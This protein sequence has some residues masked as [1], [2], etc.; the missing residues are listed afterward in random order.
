MIEKDNYLTKAQLWIIGAFIIFLPFNHALTFNYGF[1]IKISE[2]AI[3]LFFCSTFISRNSRKYLTIFSDT[4]FF[5][6]IVFFLIALTIST[7]VNLFWQYPY[8]LD[9]YNARFNPKAD[10]F[11]KLIY[12]F[13]AI[14]SC[15]VCIAAFKDNKPLFLNLFILGATLSSIY[16]WYLFSFSLLKIQYYTLPGSEIHPQAAL[17]KFGHFIRCGTFKEGNMMGMF[18]VTAGFIALYAKRYILAAFIFLTTITTASSMAI[19]C[20]VVFLS[21]Y[22]SWWLFMR[23]KIRILALLHISILVI[24]ISLLNFQDFKYMIS[25]IVPFNGSEYKDAVHSQSERINLA[26]VSLKIGLDNPV[27]GV[28]L[29]NFAWHYLHYNENEHFLPRKEKI[30]SNNVFAE[31]FAETGIISLLLFLLCIYSSYKKSLIDKSG[32]LRF[33]LLA[34][35]VY[36]L[37]FPT[38]TVLF[39]WCFL[40]LIWHLNK[41]DEHITIQSETIKIK[42]NEL[43]NSH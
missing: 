37:A 28:G 4:P 25:K 35:I 16:C 33:G 20:S 10:S 21:C 40:G 22:F 31:L 29:T 13:I 34:T 6:L 30:L 23:N 8:Q 9:F 32:I 24:F 1:P 5:K 27:F 18:L 11:L 42:S 15:G 7:I 36:W 12:S 26:M 39:S 2:F 41:E 43:E 38:F 3:F 19:F 17:F 14:Y